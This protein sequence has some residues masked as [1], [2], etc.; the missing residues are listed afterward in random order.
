MQRTRMRVLAADR[1]VLPMTQTPATPLLSVDNLSVSFGT[2]GGRV[3][4]VEDVSFA[5]PAGKTV[6]LVGES[7]CG[8]SVTAHDGHAPAA[9]AA[10]PHRWRAHPVRRRRTCRACRSTRCAR[11]RGDRIGMIFQEPMTSLNPTLTVGFQI[12]EVLRL[13]RG[14]GA[15][16]RA[17]WSDRHAEA[18]RH[19]RRRAARS[20]SIRIS[21][22]AAC[23]SA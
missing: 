14:M 17:R 12:A 13:H 20:T 10:E 8:K 7:G 2:D 19:R 16:R 22:P 21:C 3:T 15:Q 1:R 5:V 11:V 4:V 6:G 23:A 9:V 18:G